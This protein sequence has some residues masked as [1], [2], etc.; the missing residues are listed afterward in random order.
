[1]DV[2]AI[3]MRMYLLRFKIFEELS[4]NLLFNNIK[5]N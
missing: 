1:M 3:C 2:V 5:N 4:E